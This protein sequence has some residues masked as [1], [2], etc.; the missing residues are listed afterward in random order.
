MFNTLHVDLDGNAGSGYTLTL[1]NT[2]TGF[3]GVGSGPGDLPDDFVYARSGVN[4][5]GFYSNSIQ[6]IVSHSFLKPL[7]LS[8]GLGSTAVLEFS[9]VDAA[10][11]AAISRTNLGLGATWLTNPNVTNFRSAIGLGWSALTNTNAATS[12]LGFTTNG[13]VVANTGTNQL[14]FTNAFAIRDA[15]SGKNLDFI[16]TDEALNAGYGDSDYAIGVGSY[17]VAIKYGAAESDWGQPILFQEGN[18]NV[19]FP[20]ATLEFIQPLAW[21]NTTNAATTRANLGFSTN[22]NSFWTATNSSNAR[23]AVGL[24]VTNSVAFRSL[25]VSNSLDHIVARF[26]G[27]DNTIP[28]EIVSSDEGLGAGYGSSNYAIGVGSAGV[29]IKFSSSESDWGSPV[30]TDDGGNVV[31]PSNFWQVAPIS[32]T[33]Q[34]QTNVTGTSTN[35]AT[36][37]RN[38]FLF[39]LAPSVSGVTNTVTLPT[40]PATTFEGDRATITHL[41]QTTNAVT[42]IRQLGAATNLIT[43]NQLDE[44]VLLMYRSGAWTLAD[45]I[46]YIEP[47][48]FSGTNA[49]ANAA[50]SRTN[51]GLGWSALTNT[52]A[53]T[54]LLGFTTNGVVVAN[55]GTNVL[56]FTN[57]NLNVGDFNFNA[58]LLSAYNVTFDFEERQIEDTD[59][60]VV[61]AWSSGI[62]LDFGLPI[63]FGTNVSATRTNLGLGLPALTNTSNVTM[64]RALSGSTNTNHPFS[65]TISVTGTNNTNTL[66]FSNGILQSVQ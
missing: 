35:A 9:G 50:A 7:T 21:N 8:Y 17:G 16:F 13:Q 4:M 52:N 63:N 45:N 51:L 57:A 56:T 66:T 20:S 19:V 26:T 33:V 11:G 27:P 6:S 47:I 43:L 44:A 53:A 61:I 40:N 1:G 37:S 34:Y 25:V 3:R 32:T 18:G 5:F 54:S 60:G 39:S 36:N 14:T 2:N 30:L 59:N 23:S 38:L 62:T 49:A 41:A 28:L 46:S 31:D 42:A 58:G 65:G 15:N 24:G 29:Q 55:T 12:L 10:T 64:M 48:F 22:L